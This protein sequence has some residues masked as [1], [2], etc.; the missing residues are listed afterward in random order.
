MLTGTM[1]QRLEGAHVSLLRQVTRKQATQR[2]NGPW[3]E[4]TEEAVLQRAGTQTLRPYIYRRQ[5][6]VVEWV[7]TRLVFDVCARE[8]GYEGRGRL[9]VP[10][11]R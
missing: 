10:W 6:T 2:T 8:T 9:R 7:A 1:I 11:W 4:V 3:Q 5:A